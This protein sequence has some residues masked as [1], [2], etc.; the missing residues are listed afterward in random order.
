MGETMPV[1]SAQLMT[2]DQAAEYLGV[3]RQVLALWRTKKT[4]PLYTKLGPGKNSQ[5]RYRLSDINDWLEANTVEPT[6]GHH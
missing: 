4:G 6:K 1:T 3:S 5:V 2:P